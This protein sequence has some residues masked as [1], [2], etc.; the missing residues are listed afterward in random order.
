LLIH[1]YLILI[2]ISLFLSALFAASEASLFSLSRTQLESLRTGRPSIYRR[3]RQLLL[4]PD[5]FLSTVVIG[6]EFLNIMIGTFV[7]GYL[8]F[9]FGMDDAVTIGIISVL[10]SSFLLLTFSE[11]LPKIIAFRMPLYIAP[12]LVFPMQW[13][14][15]LLT[16]F[17]RIFMWISNRVV[18]FY[19]IQIQPPPAISEQDF[20]TLVEAGAESGSLERDEKEMIKNVFHFSDL[21]VAAIMTPWD[22][23]FVVSETTSIEELRFQLRT[24]PFSRIPV[25]TS[26][27]RVMGIL[28]TK[29]LLKLSLAGP[30]ANPM[31]SLHEATFPPY[32]VS[33]HKKISKLFREF[34]LKKVHIALVVDEFGKQLGVVTLEDVLN[35][36]FQPQRKKGQ[37][38]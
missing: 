20:L 18:K 34:K 25:I 31:R 10:L 2:P 14:N 22:K 28:Y 1:I 35:A 37:S 19:G 6:N 7:T 15:F 33:S 29:E 3:I 17:R 23:V 38:T 26:Q 4:R 12:V 32:I 8:E 11:I 27:N 30:S 16:P 24:R 13:A 21:T 9:Q 36:L 5:A